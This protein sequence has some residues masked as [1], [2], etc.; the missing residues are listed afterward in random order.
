M[1]NLSTISKSK[2][3][4]WQKKDKEFHYR[5]TMYD[6]VRAKNG[7]VYCINDHQEHTLFSNLENILKGYF[8]KS[9]DQKNGMAQLISIFFAEYIPPIQ[10][11]FIPIYLEQTKTVFYLKNEHIIA[12]Y[13]ASLLRPPAFNSA[14]I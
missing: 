10:H 6:I 12:S 5:G 1:F 9:N 2:E 14:I 11:I 13:N 3:F 4:K 8:S 7:K